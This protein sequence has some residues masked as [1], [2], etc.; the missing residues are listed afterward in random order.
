M[1][2]NP[3][4]KLRPLRKKP[5]FTVSEAEKLGVY[6]SLLAYHSRQ[7]RIER[8][9][10][11]LY[12]FPDSVADIPID[13]EDL[14]VAATSIPD[15][16][17]CLI[18]ALA[19]Y[20]LTDQLP[21]QHWIAVPHSSRAPRREKVR[22]VRMRNAELGATTIKLGD[23]QLRIFNRER[24]VVDAFR[25]LDKEIAIKALKAYLQGRIKG[26]KPDLRKLGSYAKTLRVSIAPYVEAFA[27]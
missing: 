15:G 23:A 8:V 7:G 1:E 10:K 11:G 3:L 21:R 13:W 20:E 2:Q 16:I 27:I 18:S 5:Y 12:R 17:V 9:G 14:I 6:A 19:M 26:H 25:Y 24:T 22:I 4:G